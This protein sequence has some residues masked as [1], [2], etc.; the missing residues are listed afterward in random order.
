M[1]S[2]PLLLLLI[3]VILFFSCHKKTDTCTSA[4]ITK[5]GTPCSNWGV[6]I[7]T[8]TYP[9][10]NIPDSL[11]QEGRVICIRYSLFEDKAVCPCCG[12]TYADITWIK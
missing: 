4:T 8:N 3:P 5:Q 12:G 1:R 6:R 10:R 9:S 7:G 11:K 2:F